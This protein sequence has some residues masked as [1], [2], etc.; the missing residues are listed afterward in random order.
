[1]QSVC[2]HCN[3]IEEWISCELHFFPQNEI[4]YQFSA[5]R[6]IPP[7]SPIPEIRIETELENGTY[8]T[9]PV[10]DCD[11]QLPPANGHQLPTITITSDRARPAA[12]TNGHPLPSGNGRQLPSANGRPLPSSAANSPRSQSINGRRLPAATT[13]HVPH[14]RQ[15]QGNFDADPPPPY[16]MTESPGG[17]TKTGHRNRSSTQ[18]ARTS[19]NHSSSPHASPSAVG[20]SAAKNTMSSKAKSM[21]NNLY[22][23][24]VLEGITGKVTTV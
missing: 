23:A 24:V 17:A 20:H 3:L 4:S 5:P 18:P 22:R 11:L 2:L 6:G 14:S 19:T 21:D 15:A 1:M 9:S 16:P 12:S 10:E 8:V 7:E 13:N